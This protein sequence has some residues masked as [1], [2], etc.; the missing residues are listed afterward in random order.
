M[1]DSL[2]YNCKY[3]YHV[4]IEFLKNILFSIEPNNTPYQDSQ[5]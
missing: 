2:M 1:N 4:L 3:S 5:N